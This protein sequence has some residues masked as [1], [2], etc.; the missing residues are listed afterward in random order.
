MARFAGAHGKRRM[1][2]RLQQLGLRRL[3][4][5]MALHA[6][7]SRERLPLMRLDQPRIFRIVTIQAERWRRFRQVIIELL[8]TAFA[9]LVRDVAGF[10]A[11][12]QCGMTATLLGDVQSLRMAAETEVLVLVT[13]GRLQKLEFVV[14]LM[15]I[16][17]LHA[18]ANRRRV[19]FA[20]DVGGVVISVA[21]EAERLRRCGDE[22][23]AGDVFIDS[24]LV[25]TCAS[26]R[27]RRVDVL[28]FGFIRVALCALG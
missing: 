15:W 27:D 9:G 18:V 21:G 11:H 23:D 2:K 4:R 24:N 13:G 28:S 5:I 14:G 12:V 3:V 20:F 22:L 25:T 6:V 19:D 26:R 10:A 8:L 1:S 17:T 16:V 7:G